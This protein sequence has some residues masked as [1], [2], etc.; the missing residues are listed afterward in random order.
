MILTIFENVQFLRGLFFLYTDKS[1]HISALLTVL[2]Q[3]QIE[4]KFIN[5]LRPEK[6]FSSLL[7]LPQQ[8]KQ[9]IYNISHL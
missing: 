1:D 2:Y 9:D 8:I 7:E 6:K 4:V 5:F 3:Q